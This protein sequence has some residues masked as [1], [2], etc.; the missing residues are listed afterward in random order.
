MAKPIIGMIPPSGWHYIDGDAR[1]TGHSYESL[2]QAVQSFRA[3]NNL[4]QGDVTGDVNSYICSNWPHYCHGVDMVVV[5][6]ADPQTAGTELMNDVQVWAKNIQ[7]SNK[8]INFVTDDIAEERA[9]ICR[10]CS[11]NYYWRGGCASCVISTERLCASI[12]QGRDTHTSI[13]LGGC[14]TQR[15]DNRTAVF[16]DKDILQKSSNLP[17]NCWL[18]ES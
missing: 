5:T 13:S 10:N 3:E 6:S 1:I 17:N 11:Q 12:R 4:P 2:I 8:Q 14:R 7:Q 15:H 16:F 9:K 18:N